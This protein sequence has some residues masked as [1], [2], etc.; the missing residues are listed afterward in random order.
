MVKCTVKIAEAGGGQA[1]GIPCG[2]LSWKESEDSLGADFSFSCPFSPYDDEYN[3]LLKVGS[4]VVVYMGSKEILRGIITTANFD[5]SYSGYDFCWYLNKSEEIL[6]LKKVA[7]DKAIKDLLKKYG[8]P[9]G[10]IPKLATSISKLYKDE[11][12]SDILRDILKRVKHET[13]KGYRLEMNQGK[14][15]IVEKGSI[16]I[17]PTYT[18]DL[19]SRKKIT[20][21]AEISGSRSIENLVNRVIVAGTDDSKKQIKATAEDSKSISKYG[22]ITQ[23]ETEDNLNEAKARNKAEKILKENDKVTVSF[24]ADMMG[25][26]DVKPCRR[27]YFENK[28]YGLKGWYKVVSCTH[29]I[30]GGI[31]KVSAEMEA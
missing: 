14:L 19:G 11:V 13:G 16:H 4:V 23:V 21:T 29:S 31:Y 8:V 26:A 1:K 15:D 10:N 30:S 18:D 27:L 3:K 9:A 12:V 25:S 20:D 17:E 5:G 7:A 6:Q 28:A 2:D 24:A 22:L